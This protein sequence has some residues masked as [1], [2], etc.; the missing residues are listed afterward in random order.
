MKQ[1]L[2]FTIM[3]AVLLFAGC[4]NNPQATP[5]PLAP[6]GK[7]ALVSVTGELVP[8]VWA[9]LGPKAGGKIVAVLVEPG[10]QVEPGAELVKLDTADLELAL[11][12][13]Q[14]QVAA[15]QAALDA[16][17]NGASDATIARADRETA[18]QLEQAKLTLAIKETQLEQAQLTDPAN[19]IALSKAQ[20][21][22]I[23]AQ[24]VQWQAQS[25]VAQVEAAQIELERAQI[26]LDD[27]QDEYKKAMDRPWEDQAVRDAWAKQL[28]QAQLNRRAAQAQ[29]VAAQNAQRAHSLGQAAFDAQ[30]LAAQT[31]LAQAVDAQAAYSLTLTI[32][33][34]EVDT[35]KLHIA[36]LE[37]W[38]NPY[39]DPPSEDEVAQ[40]EAM[41]RQ[42]Q[43]QAAQIEQQIQDATLVA[44]FGGTVG[45]VYARVGE[46]A[47]PGQPLAVVGDLRTLRVQTTDLDEIDVARLHLDQQ[48][49][50]TFDAF[51]D[52][53]FPGRITRISPM[54]QPGSGGVNYAVVI[55]LTEL[56]PALKWGMTAFVDIDVK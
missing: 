6:G 47:A 55:E 48:V 44:P 11:A 17:K 45:A 53:V 43:L 3:A 14:Q 16:L 24:I 28:K 37:G 52:R 12:L 23:E 4:Q 56:N 22:Q 49:A 33:A 46:V 31:G 34:Q 39:R 21:A 10:D 8:E 13:A 15:Q 35:L 27:T 26:A 54:S 2:S 25:P 7:V 18:F 32:L 42:A 20:I 36:H 5:T 51:P 38:T 19:N 41:L 50:V 40:L 9:S 30:R 29:L 1:V